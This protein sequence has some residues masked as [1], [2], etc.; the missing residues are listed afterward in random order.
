MMELGKLVAALICAG[1][2][3]YVVYA[4]ARGITV[5]Q[6]IFAGALVLVALGLT[7]LAQ[8]Q[9]MLAALA[10]YAAMLPGVKA[11]AASAQPQASAA[12]DVAKEE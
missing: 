8:L 1:I 5:P 11:P 6:M 7:L 4:N 12:P 10:P 2:A 3:G 9:K